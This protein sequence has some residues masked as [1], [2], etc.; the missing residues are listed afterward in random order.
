MTRP[1]DEADDAPKLVR[2]RAMPLKSCVWLHPEADLSDDER[3]S[4]AQELARLAK[5]REVN[6]GAR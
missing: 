4:L 5:A 3:E 6:G 2:K 1:Q